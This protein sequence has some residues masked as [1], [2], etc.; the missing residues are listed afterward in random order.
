M[1]N[2]EKYLDQCLWY[3]NFCN[4]IVKYN[5]ISVSTYAD[6]SKKKNV[7]TYILNMFHIYT[8][9]YI[10]RISKVVQFHVSFISYNASKYYW[11]YINDGK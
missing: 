2:Y 10:N 4:V 9:I 11:K 7:K 3:E 5:G 6:I 1:H 8:N